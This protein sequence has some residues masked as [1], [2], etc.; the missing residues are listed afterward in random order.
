MLKRI[1]GLEEHKSSTTASS[2]HPLRIV[3]GGWLQTTAKEDVERDCEE[4]MKKLPPDLRLRFHKPYAPRPTESMATCRRLPDELDK[5]QFILQKWLETQNLPEHRWC[6]A[7]RPREVDR[8]KRTVKILTE[9]LS[10]GA[11]QV[12]MN[13]DI[14]H[15]SVAVAKWSRD[16]PMWTHTMRGP[17]CTGRLGRRP[18]RSRC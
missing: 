9:Q 10:V 17:V 2:R 15:G 6:I 18:R 14:C 4:L 5:T 1:D 13:S 8:R 12:D 11:L 16:R 7:E 3:S